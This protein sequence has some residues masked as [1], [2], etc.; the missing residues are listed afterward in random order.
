[1]D[2]ERRRVLEKVDDALVIDGETLIGNSTLTID[3]DEFGNVMLHKR[4]GP[5]S[6]DPLGDEAIISLTRSQ[7]DAI[8][9]ARNKWDDEKCG[10][11]PS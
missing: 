11:S 2:I 3:L 8:V 7:I 6:F 1:M 10:R 5:S 4:E 9:G